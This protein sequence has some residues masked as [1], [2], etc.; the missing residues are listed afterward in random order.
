MDDALS[1]LLCVP[2]TVLTAPIGYGKTTAIRQYIHA[3]N[4]H[5]IWTS[6]TP[7]DKYITSFWS[8]FTSQIQKHNTKLGQKL[9]FLG[10]P[11]NEAQK[12]RFL[13]VFEK[14]IHRKT[15]IFIMDN[16]DFVCCEEVN[17]FIE[18]LVCA[19][20]PM[21][22][23]IL[24]SNTSTFPFHD[25][26]PV[27]SLC[28]HIDST[29]FAVRYFE[30]TK[31][32]EQFSLTADQLTIFP[33]TECIATLSLMIQRLHSNGNPLTSTFTCTIPSIINDQY[34]ALSNEDQKT[35]LQ[36]SLLGEF[37]FLEAQ[38]LTGDFEISNT[39]TR[40]TEQFSLLEYMSETDQFVFHR[41]FLDFVQPLWKSNEQELQPFW[42][43]IGMYYFRQGDLLRASLSF[44][45]IN[46]FEIILSSLN[47]KNLSTFSYSSWLEL[48]DIFS[49]QPHTLWI[50]YPM[51][52]LQF[53]CYAALSG[54]QMLMKKSREIL[55]V[56]EDYFLCI[57][58]ESKDFCTHILAEIE[59]IRVFVAFNKVDQMLIHIDKSF[60]L[61][62]G[63]TSQLY[64]PKN[65][66]NFACP[67]FSFSYYHRIMD[68]KSIVSIIAQNFN[69][70]IHI[71]NGCMS[72]CDIQ[73][74]VERALER[75]E[76][77]A[78]S[79][80]CGA[81]LLAYQAK[82]RAR[83]N[84][85]PCISICSEFAIMRICLL[86]GRLK[87][88]TQRLFELRCYIDNQNDALLNT[89][90]DLCRGYLYACIGK[91]ELIPEWLQ[92]GNFRAEHMMIEGLG[93]EYIIY[94]KVLILDHNWTQL[95]EECK[96]FSKYN[97]LY[98][99]QLGFLHNHIHYAVAKLHLYGMEEAKK[100][101]SHAL[102]IGR[103]EYFILPFIEDSPYILAILEE[104][105]LEQN[106]PYRQELLGY[107]QKFKDRYS[108]CQEVKCILTRREIEVLKQIQS[109]IKIELIAKNLN[110]TR[111]TIHHHFE[112]INQKLGTRNIHQSIIKAKNLNILSS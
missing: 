30:I 50:K 70:L 1:N 74:L 81:S 3:K 89:S 16:F 45:Y 40:L 58:D 60:T 23:I 62:N 78:R 22:H 76:W 55:S 26:S 18:F 82:E 75:G 5:A 14:I 43:R 105:C 73:V 4:L 44:A 28:N 63:R 65:R 20:I 37:T 13:D 110:V 7:S 93:L 98:N 102:V 19:D 100:E 107:C 31:Y 68:L 85:Q 49:T 96:R 99:C 42:E 10:F 54:N 106:A 24:I 108:N 92:K 57:S 6:F 86:Q 21:L 83:D 17:A 33:S 27:I 84:K 59:V 104:L 64:F 51:V 35:L 61:F 56:L 8:K 109:G 34:S 41:L 52:Y 90:V 77:S 12:E 9:A 47:K 66:F 67:H 36:L 38:V 72:G 69:R 79:D 53:A 97:S 2:L 80:W 111:S 39:L 11:V 95:E 112:N 91:L 101:F 71:T 32:M 88:M 46:N 94:Q 87:E 25:S 103:A 29:V 48:E 15:L